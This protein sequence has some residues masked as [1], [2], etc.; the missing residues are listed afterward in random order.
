LQA[1]VVAAGYP[2]LLS[3]VYVTSPS[4]D[5]TYSNPVQFV[6]YAKGSA[7]ITSMKIFVDGV[8]KYSVSAS[9]LHTS[10]T[11]SVG[12]RNIVLQAWDSNGKT[13]KRSETI[14]VK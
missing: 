7:P 14:T 5:A 6:A 12:T 11:L 1:P 3:G 8:S 9:S 2:A 4:V 13:Y 10:L